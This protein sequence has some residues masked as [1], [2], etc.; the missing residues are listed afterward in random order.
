MHRI[1]AILQRDL[2][3][4]SRDSLLLYM[5]IGPIILMVGMRFFLPGVGQSALTLVVTQ[6]DAPY[7]QP[8]LDP[9]AQVEVVANR[10]ALTERVLAY[11]E[12]P[13][14]LSDGDGFTVVLAG[15]E[16]EEMGLLPGLILEQA[17]S[18][19]LPE[20]DI[21]EVGETAVP[22]REWPF[23]EWIAIFSTLTVLFISSII[24]AF[25]IIEDKETRMME[26]MGV[27]PLNRKTYV[28]ARSLFVIVMAQLNVLLALWA[29]GVTNFDVGQ[30]VMATAA[31]SL[32]AILFGF[33][34][35]ALS[36][37]Q[38]SGI[39][40]IKFGFL[41]ILLPA[42]LTFFLPTGWEPALY[43]IPTYWAFVSFK[44]ILL[45]GINW[46]GLWPLLFWN[47]AVSTACLLLA[48]P[49]LKGRLSFAQ[50]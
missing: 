15:N 4:T 29:L 28:L 31:G 6:A 34:V 13:G 11:D 26:V 24:M 14:I 2:I 3:S 45:E 27:S 38:I 49:W 35:G 23:R 8:L 47:V 44:A 39:A 50:N 37:N 43:W 20:V 33:L 7:L 9:Y 10:T 21:T 5:L 19:R 36:H 18:G 25:H 1:I 48:Y 42:L 32:V 30:M 16:S 17:L 40:N 22:F 41:L 12:V 46:A